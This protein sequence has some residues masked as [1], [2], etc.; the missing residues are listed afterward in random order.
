MLLRTHF[1]GTFSRSCAI[2]NS[3][4]LGICVGTTMNYFLDD[5]INNAAVLFPGVGCFLIAACLGSWL[6]ASNVADIDKKLGIQRGGDVIDRYVIRSYPNWS[7]TLGF[8]SLGCCSS[9]NSQA[10]TA[11]TDATYYAIW[12]LN[13]NLHVMCACVCITSCVCGNAQRLTS[14][15][16]VAMQTSWLNVPCVLQSHRA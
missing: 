6:H 4:G 9:S 5:R 15:L 2:N 16:F 12:A 1:V 3:T 11:D 7:K 14:T 10:A 13:P 8:L